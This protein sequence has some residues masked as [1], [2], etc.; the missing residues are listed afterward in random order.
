MCGL[1]YGN[2]ETTKNLRKKRKK[3]RKR[4]KGGRKKEKKGGGEGKVLVV[5]TMTIPRRL[6]ALSS[7]K[8]RKMTSS[9][10]N[11]VAG[12]YRDIRGTTIAAAR[13]LC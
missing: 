13:I 9:D 4:K 10:E 5:F 11:P 3:T 6:G 2:P 1:L 7:R 12:R 8:H